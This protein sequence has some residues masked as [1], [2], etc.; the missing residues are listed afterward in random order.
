LNFIGSLI[1]IFRKLG[2]E[3]GFLRK[4]FLEDKV[5][6]LKALRQTLRENFTGYLTIF[7]S[8]GFF[9]TIWVDMI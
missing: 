6:F 3:G 8:L 9:M 1:E 7:I 2:I 5:L 4:A